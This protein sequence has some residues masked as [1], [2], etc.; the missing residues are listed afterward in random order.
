MGSVNQ[1]V[2]WITGA[3]SGIGTELAL[4]F[5]RRKCKS[6]LSGRKVDAL[7][8][9]A[10]QAQLLGAP[11]VWVKPFDATD[12]SVIPS[13]QTLFNSEENNWWRLRPCLNNLLLRGLAINLQPCIFCSQRQVEMWV[14]K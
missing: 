1:S 5:A 14:F 2:V 9:V 3:S 12:F 6:V 4:A 11:H 10:D 13:F 7:Q 8:T